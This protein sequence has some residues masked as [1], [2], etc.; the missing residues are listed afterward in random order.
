M[1]RILLVEDDDLARG[2]FRT[3]LEGEGYEVVEA[4]NGRDGVRL[5]RESPCDLIVMDIFMPRKSGLDALVELDPNASGIPVIAIS[6]AGGGTGADPLHL[7]ETLGAARTFRKPFETAAFL[8]GV[9][10]L[11]GD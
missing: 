9:K 3:L 11:I 4:R 7:A 8:A 10:E 5:F 6:G 1:K 2:Y